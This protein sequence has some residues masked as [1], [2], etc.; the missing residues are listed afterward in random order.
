MI[1]CDSARVLEGASSRS[2]FGG[3]VARGLCS[4]EAGLA[5]ERAQL[6]RFRRTARVVR[7]LEPPELAS[8]SQERVRRISKG[9]RRGAVCNADHCPRFQHS[10]NLLE[11]GERG[12]QVLEDR[13]GEGRV[14]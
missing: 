13:T 11:R 2:G 8:R 7:A 14:E 3:Q 5:E 4:R 1:L 12:G 10:T 6:Q 9:D